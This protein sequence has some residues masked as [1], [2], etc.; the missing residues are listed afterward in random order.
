[1]TREKTYTL[2]PDLDIWNERPMLIKELDGLIVRC[3]TQLDAIEGRN[4]IV[5]IKAYDDDSIDFDFYDSSTKSY[6]L[7]QQVK[8]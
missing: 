2:K 5:M 4:Q 8:L 7:I 1:M 6:K 3:R